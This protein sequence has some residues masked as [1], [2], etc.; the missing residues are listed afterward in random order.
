MALCHRLSYPNT[1]MA[2]PFTVEAAVTE[3]LA[4]PDYAENVEEIS[5]KYPHLPGLADK[6]RLHVLL[7]RDWLD[8]F[9]GKE[10]N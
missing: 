2:Q 4:N 5:H 10:L 9:D 7:N 8:W 3:L 6:L 1:I